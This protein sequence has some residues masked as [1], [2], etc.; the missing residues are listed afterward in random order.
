[1]RVFAKLFWRN[2]TLYEKYWARYKNEWNKFRKRI[3]LELVGMIE[4]IC[5]D[6]SSAETAIMATKQLP[7]KF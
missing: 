2:C 5:M 3:L 6:L 1:M 4:T 7:R